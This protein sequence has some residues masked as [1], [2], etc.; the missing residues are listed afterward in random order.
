MGQFSNTP[1]PDT[2]TSVSSITSSS[3]TS[4]RVTVC[5]AGTA[6]LKEGRG[7]GEASLGLGGITESFER[8]EGWGVGTFSPEPG[9]G[10]DWVLVEESLSAVAAGFFT[11]SFSAL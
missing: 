9:G 7:P 4:L 6:E 8:R 10:D 1:S 5:L 11:L 2:F 3:L